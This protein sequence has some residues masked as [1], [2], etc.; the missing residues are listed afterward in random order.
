[1]PPRILD[2]WFFVLFRQKRDRLMTCVLGKLSV[3]V[4][5]VDLRVVEVMFMLRPI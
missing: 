5:R 3:C 4:A 1:M 2:M